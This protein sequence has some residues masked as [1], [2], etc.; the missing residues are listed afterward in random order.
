MRVIW[1][2]GAGRRTRGVVRLA[3]LTLAVLAV[4]G[5]LAS[6]VV[7]LL[8][9]PSLDAPWDKVRPGSRPPARPSGPAAEEPTG[10]GGLP[11]GT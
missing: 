6:W 11:G 2:P 4:A 8:C 9:P 1:V 10:P 7:Y 3:V 5:F